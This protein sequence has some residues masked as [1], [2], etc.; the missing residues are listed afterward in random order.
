MAGKSSS[1]VNGALHKKVQAQ[2]SPRLL[3]LSQGLDIR[4]KLGFV[5]RIYG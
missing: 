1:W 3:E 2:K 5:S 4:H